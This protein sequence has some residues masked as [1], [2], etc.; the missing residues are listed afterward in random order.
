MT[1]QAFPVIHVHSCLLFFGKLAFIQH[2]PDVKTSLPSPIAPSF[3]AIPTIISGTAHP[4][5]WKTLSKISALLRCFFATVTYMKTARNVV[6][7]ND[8]KEAVVETK[9]CAMH[10]VG[11]VRNHVPNK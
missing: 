11:S 9:L 6:Q 3:K 7:K 10:D 2:H 1:S 4:M 8:H 5:K